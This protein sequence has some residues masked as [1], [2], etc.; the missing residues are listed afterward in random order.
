MRFGVS[1]DMR[2]PENVIKAK[3]AG[4]DYIECNFNVMAQSSQEEFDSFCSALDEAG[5]K[6]ETC[7]GLIPRDIPLL[8]KGYSKTKLTQHLKSGFSRCAVLGVDTVVLGSGKARSYPEYMTYGEGFYALSRVIGDVIAPL[9]E[10]Y[11][12]MIVI[13]PLNK[14]ETNIINTVKEGVMLASA[15]RRHNVSGLVDLYHMALE[16]DTIDN[17]R[18]VK[19]NLSHA[20]IA[21]PFET[22][23]GRKARSYPAGEDEYDYKG[24]I[25][26]ISYAGCKRC[27]VEASVIDLDSDLILSGKLFQKYK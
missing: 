21:N 6:C 22:K 10:E 15:S 5:I 8:G 26:A 27:S 11:G 14:G 24:F 19:G 7:N 2:C 9:A 17:I 12:I 13:E 1:M 20:H 18:Q 4:F 16:G 25:D 23:S 3:N